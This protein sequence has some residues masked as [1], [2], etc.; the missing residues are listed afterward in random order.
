MAEVI[1]QYKDEFASQ[2]KDIMA[3]G[4]TSQIKEIATKGFATVRVCTD[5]DYHLPTKEF[6]GGNPTIQKLKGFY[7]KL[8]D[9]KAATA[10]YIKDN[11]KLTCF[12]YVY[13]LTDFGKELFQPYKPQ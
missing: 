4:F 7:D 11:R 1:K 12:S 3:A 6:P 13:D 8:V 2:I 5:G 10:P 9:I